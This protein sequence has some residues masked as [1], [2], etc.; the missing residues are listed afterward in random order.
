MIYEATIT[1]WKWIVKF[2]DTLFF[3]WKYN[4]NL[5]SSSV[6]PGEKTIDTLLW[7]SMEI[8]LEAGV[9]YF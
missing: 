5:I 9:P 3:F 6:L 4:V 1:F 2:F 8:C 7:V